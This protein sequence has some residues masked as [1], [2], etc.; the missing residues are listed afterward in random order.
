MT[1]SL[2]VGETAH[3]RLTPRR[4]GFRYRLFQLLLDID[5]IDE[6]LKG[7]KLIRQGRF[8]LFSFDNRDHGWRDWLPLRGWVEARLAE[9]GVAATAHRIRLLTFPRILGF[10]FN[11]ISLFYV[12]DAD[13][14]LEAVIYEVNS[15]FG[16]TH[17]Y[18][19]PAAGPG[20][21]RQTADKQLYV[22]P[23]YGLE[24]SYRFDVTPPDETLNLSIVKSTDGRPD[25]TATLALTRRPLTDA[26]LLAQ[27]F[28]MPLL[29]L[30]VVAAIHWEALRLFLK[31][32]PL[33]RR[34]T[35][36]DVG[37]SRASLRSRATRENNVILPATEGSANDA[38]E[39]D[40]IHH[41]PAR[42]G[43]AGLA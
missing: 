41:Q 22:S 42:T 12:E 19:A 13:G 18:V 39:P 25:F 3:L 16:Q 43:V 10:V 38:D 28:S 5:R 36:P 4:H 20:P 2:Y 21:Q 24:G 17:A 35:A 34:P 29:T 40:A 14:R 32:V 1:A 6:D 31:G 30:K 33:V 7:L 23:F 11:P 37:T 15:T 27:F 26:A 8:G 9:A